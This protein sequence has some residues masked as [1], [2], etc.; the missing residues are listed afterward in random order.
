MECILL[1]SSMLSNR[2]YQKMRVSLK[3]MLFCAF[4]ANFVI[5]DDSFH[6]ISNYFVYYNLFYLNPICYLFFNK[7]R[8]SVNNFSSALGSAGFSGS[9]SGARFKL[10]ITLTIAKTA[11]AIIKKSNTF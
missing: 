7:S 2:N 8:I 3:I 1:I 5:V 6:E 10:L 4:L 9:G 11:A